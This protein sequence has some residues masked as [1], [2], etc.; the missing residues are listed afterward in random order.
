MDGG[1]QKVKT[2]DYWDSFY[3]SL[4]SDGDIN[5][6]VDQNL[7]EKSSSGLEWIVPHSAVLE[8]IS[9]LFPLSA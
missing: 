6:T 8:T 4:P 7:G 9:S 5:S 3:S 2:K 1:G